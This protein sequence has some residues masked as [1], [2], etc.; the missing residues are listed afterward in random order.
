[1][2]ETRCLTASMIEVGMR[3]EAR[4]CFTHEQV[5]QYCAL[6]GDANAIHRE[7]EAARVRFPDTPDI[8]VPGGLVQTCVSALFAT[9]LPGDGS[10]GL[11]F[12]PER[13]RRPVCPGDELV[14]T[15][16]V[17]RILRG[18]IVEMAVTVEDGEGERLSRATAKIVPPDEAYRAWWQA[19]IA[20][21]GD[22]SSTSIGSSA[23]GD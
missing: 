21:K 16:E 2:K 3:H 11:T 18:G 19:H 12:S 20:G 13:F 4:L 23:A 1:M 5:A 15:L 8:I 9:M 6:T 14:V 10:L 17:A 7:L 22:E